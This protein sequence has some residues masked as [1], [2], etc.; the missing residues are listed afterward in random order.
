MLYYFRYFL[1]NLPSISL[2][3]TSVQDFL[4]GDFL[5]LVHVYDKLSEHHLGLLGRWLDLFSDEVPL[6]FEDIGHGKSYEEIS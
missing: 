6:Y 4:S 3:L 1:L 5:V 2:Q